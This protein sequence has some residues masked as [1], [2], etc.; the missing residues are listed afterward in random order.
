[1]R[2]ADDRLNDESI[3]AETIV[4]SGASGH[5][6]GDRALFVGLVRSCRVPIAGVSGP[7]A[8]MA[9]GV[10]AGELHLST[11]VVK[12][13][14][15]YY[16]PGLSTT[17][18]SASALVED[19]YEVRISKLHGTHSMRLVSPHQEQAIVLPICAMACIIALKNQNRI[20]PCSSPSSSRPCVE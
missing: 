4:D 10:G 1:M 16:V 17:L 15:L 5:M 7:S 9:T 18:V 14:R 11:G 6:T 2:V 12:L 8:S 13:N 3:E 20:G 19:G